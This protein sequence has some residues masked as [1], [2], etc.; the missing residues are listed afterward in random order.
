MSDQTGAHPAPSTSSPPEGSAA[1]PDADTGADPYL[2]LEEIDGEQALDFVHRHS[3]RAEDALAVTRRYG[4]LYRE[5]LDVLDA[6]DRIPMPVWRGGMLYN[7]WTDAEHERGVWRRTTPESYASE[8]PEWEVLL[9]L[10]A[11]NAAEGT[12]WV[13]KGAEVLYPAHTRALVA[14]SPGGSDATVVREFDLATKTF[15][16]DGFHLPQ[17]KGF[18]TWADRAGSAI[19]VARDAG[20]GSMTRSGYPRTIR[21]WERGTPLTKAPVLFEGSVDDVLVA[22]SVDLT[23]GYER[24][25]LRRATTFYT[26]EAH[27]LDEE[28]GAPVHIPVPDS[29]EI[30]VFRDWLV[31]LLREPWELPALTHEAGTLLGIRLDAFLAGAR[32]LAVLFEPTPTTS[33]VDWTWT[34]SHLL[35]TI[36]DDVRHRIDVL[37]PPQAVTEP[38]ATATPAGEG[39]PATGSPQAR[40]AWRRRLASIREGAAVPGLEDGA[41]DPFPTLSVTAID[42][43]EGD[44]IWIVV[45]GFLTPT[46]LAHGLLDDAGALAG[47]EVLKS[48]PARFDAADF[49][50]TQH[51]VLSE[52]GTRVPYFQIGPRDGEGR[53]PRPTLLYG[54]GGFEVP[55]LPGYLGAIG[56]VWLRRGGVHVV[57]NIRGGGEYGPRWHRS[58]LREHRHRAYEDFAAVAQDLVDRGVTT[59]AQLGARGGS[60]GGLLMGNMLTR[61]PEKFG[62]IVCQV[63]LLDMKRYS[64][65]L[66]G[67]SWVAEYGDP[68]VPADWAFLREYSAYHQV[69]PAAAH[70]PILLTTSTRDDRVHPGHARKMTALLESLGKDVTFWEN[71][72]GG[73][74]GAASNAQ[75]STMLAL[76]YEFLWQRLGH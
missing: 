70:P 32:D 45:S 64:H 73:H 5:I 6:D 26:S 9:D 59:P 16:A 53:A 12:S 19:L 67:A 61:Y 54:Y 24:T 35:L 62:A 23:E 11:L 43:R 44:R 3:R 58:A 7:F 31:I 4:E 71:T 39:G 51:F 30:D 37:T 25:V 2:D 74:G 63:P 10:D 46:T 65:L 28:T 50:V 42:P 40:R 66:A 57:A 52:D 14:L 76:A 29:A 17:S 72:E 55:E 49:R 69:D 1:L 75:R 48:S 27:I 15:V 33:L 41:A 21:R 38:A 13:W 22:P 68:D 18:A 47:A 36:L 56:R 8:N 20:E 60:N 34:R